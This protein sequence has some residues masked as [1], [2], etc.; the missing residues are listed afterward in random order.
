MK[1]CG[2]LAECD[3]YVRCSLAWL[4]AY[5]T[6]ISALTLTLTSR[7]SQS[8]SGRPVDPSLPNCHQAKPSQVALSASPLR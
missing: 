5:R 2:T 8:P 6:V 1:L 4:Y 7:N 3:L